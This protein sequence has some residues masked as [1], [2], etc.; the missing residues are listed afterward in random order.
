MCSCTLASLFV[1]LLSIVVVSGSPH[2]G[3]LEETYGL[4][5]LLFTE[6][7]EWQSADVW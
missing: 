6:R 3:K 1:N 4:C 2:T 7:G 5:C